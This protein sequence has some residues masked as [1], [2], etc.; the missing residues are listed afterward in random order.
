VRRQGPDPGEVAEYLQQAAHAFLDGRDWFPS[1][2]HHVGGYQLQVTRTPWHLACLDVPNAR[3]TL[4][5]GKPVLGTEFLLQETT[6]NLSQA[7]LGA[8]F[9]VYDVVDQV[10]FSARDRKLAY[11]FVNELGSHVDQT[12]F[13]MSLDGSLL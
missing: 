1:P 3:V 11:C 4:L 8:G 7:V 12:Y 6:L 13:Q 10:W 5:A 2:P 9:T